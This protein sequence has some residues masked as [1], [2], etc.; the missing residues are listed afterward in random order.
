MGPQGCTGAGFELFVTNGRC[1]HMLL[2]TKK[3]TLKI[4]QKPKIPDTTPFIS[5]IG[6]PKAI[7]TI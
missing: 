1:A 7:A 3:E 4:P 6:L 2:L 5:Q